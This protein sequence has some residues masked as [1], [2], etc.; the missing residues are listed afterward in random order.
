LVLTLR[1]SQNGNM[2]YIE[3]AK[4]FEFYSSTSKGA[5]QGYGYEMHKGEMSMDLYARIVIPTD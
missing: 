3:K 4:N 2:I 5:V 1:R